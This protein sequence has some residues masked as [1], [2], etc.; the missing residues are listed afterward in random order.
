VYVQYDVH[1]VVQLIG[2][3]QYKK[4]EDIGNSSPKLLLY[5]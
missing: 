2:G 5:T 1:A 3:P 4:K